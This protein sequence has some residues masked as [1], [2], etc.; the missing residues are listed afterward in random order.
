MK[1]HN[2]YP[3]PKYLIIWSFWTLGVC[4][5]SSPSLSSW[6]LHFRDT[7]SAICKRQNL[8]PKALN[9]KQPRTRSP[10]KALSP[11]GLP[12]VPKGMHIQLRGHM[13]F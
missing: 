12:L 8:N 10:R 4:Q 13:D 7:S 2:Y 5:T 11:K 1:L 3:K 9:P 6:P